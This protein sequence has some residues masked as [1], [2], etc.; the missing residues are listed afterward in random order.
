[1]MRETLERAAPHVLSILRIVV[2]LLFLEHGTVKLFGFPAPM[3]PPALFSM[4]WFAAIIEIAGGALLAVGLFT[5]TVAF[6]ISARWRSPISSSTRRR[7]FILTSTKGSWRSSTALSFSISS[8][9]DP[10]RG[11]STRCGSRDAARFKRL[12]HARRCAG[13]R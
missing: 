13:A 7:A 9:P 6:I 1:M 8:S 5:R 4:L 10:A 12:V 11:A 3:A 2:G